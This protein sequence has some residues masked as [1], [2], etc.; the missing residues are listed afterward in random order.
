MK[1]DEILLLYGTCPDGE[2]ARAIGRS[3]L[4]AKLVACVN[5]LPGMT[6]LFQ[7]QG[8]LE[9]CSEVVLIAKSRHGVWDEV[10]RLYQSLHPYEEPALVAL[11]V[12]DGL[13]GFLNWVRTETTSTGDDDTRREPLP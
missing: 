3:L 13:P 8:Q 5:I 9:E 1:N 4:E 11:P 2:T 6:A 10:A 7:W 12:S